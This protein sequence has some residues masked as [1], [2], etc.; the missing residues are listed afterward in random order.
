[1]IRLF[2]GSIAAWLADTPV[3]AP[4]PRSD[5]S[6]RSQ[7]RPELTFLGVSEFAPSI[8]DAAF[9]L[10]QTV[11]FSMRCLEHRTADAVP[12]TAPRR[13]VCPAPSSPASFHSFPGVC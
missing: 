1:M 3:P 8:V 4:L 7:N 11:T 10:L 5:A 6:E 12:R 13:A 2:D 9:S